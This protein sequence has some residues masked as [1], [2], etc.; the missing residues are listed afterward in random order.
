MNIAILIP[1]LAGG[2][3]ERMA[4]VLGDHYVDKGYGVYYF[5]ADVGLKADY[6]VK[7]KIIQTGIK[8]C[9]FGYP[10]KMQIISRLFWNS[11]E[12]RRLKRHY[13]IDIAISFMEE[14][15][16][17][18]ILSKGDEKVITCV[19]AILSR[20]DELK[21]F[22]YDRK[23]VRFFYLKAEQ[24]VVV[25]N[26]ALKDMYSYYGIPRNKLLMIPNPA[27]NLKESEENFLWT[28]GEKVVVCIG[29]LVPVKQ[30]E[31]IIRAFAYACQD[32]PDAKLV[33][34][35][36][37]PQMSYLK[38]MSE[39]CGIREKVIFVGFVDNVWFYLKNARVFVMAS[40]SEGFPNSMVEAMYYGVPVITTDSPG[41]CGEIVG[42][43]KRIR[44]INSILYCEYGVLTPDIPYKK[45][46]SSTSLMGQEVL[47][48]L[49]MQEMLSKDELYERYHRQSLRRAESYSMNRVMEKWDSVLKI[50]ERRKLDE[51]RNHFS[52]VNADRRSTGRKR[53][54]KIYGGGSKEG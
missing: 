13:K 49:A 2:G 37:G 46:K 20:C 21:G 54:R 7:G 4:Q 45:V 25:S 3:A 31:K 5:L 50:D 52:F 24:V 38:R 53:N 8:G 39:N 44:E 1:T 26:Y 33:I 10:N 42:K 18:N 28:Y 12:M 29:R 34:L 27:H 43:P 48:G 15:N 32:E 6:K 35:G 11:L 19:C 17:L 14:F 9:M 36:K 22:L 23:V 41:G 51:K 16:Y 30:H 40:Q 47:L